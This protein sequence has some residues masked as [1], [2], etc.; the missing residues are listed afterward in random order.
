MCIASH[1]H[2]ETRQ[3]SFS[4]Q[5][6]N[7]GE[8]TKEIK[9]VQT[10]ALFQKHVLDCYIDFILNMAGMLFSNKLFIFNSVVFGVFPCV[11]L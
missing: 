1:D 5:W 11:S 3:S 7:D 2:A 6:E 9:N 10:K 8:T 4:R